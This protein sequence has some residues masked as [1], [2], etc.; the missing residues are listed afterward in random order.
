M[1]G[2][3]NDGNGNVHYWH[4]WALVDQ[5]VPSDG[6]NLFAYL[7]LS[8]LGLRD[9]SKPTNSSIVLTIMGDEK[10]PSYSQLRVTPRASTQSEWLS[11]LRGIA[12]IVFETPYTAI[13]PA[14][15]AKNKG[16]GFPSKALHSHR[17]T[18]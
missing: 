4:A 10:S 17:S 5:V 9:E 12:G 8:Y 11:H 2:D 1:A 18:G 7:T 3:E 6:C 16:L 15:G 13:P 14:M